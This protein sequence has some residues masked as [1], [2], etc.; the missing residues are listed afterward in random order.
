M[1]LSEGPT[2]RESVQEQVIL[3]LLGSCVRAERRALHPGKNKTK[4]ALSRLWPD[5]SHAFFVRWLFAILILCAVI[6]CLVKTVLGTT[7]LIRG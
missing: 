6:C 2:S 1:W 3:L 4:A 5:D 7:E